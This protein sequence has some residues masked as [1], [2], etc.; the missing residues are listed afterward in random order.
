MSAVKSQASYIDNLREI[1]H[2]QRNEAGSARPEDDIWSALIVAIYAY[3]DDLFAECGVAALP[4]G[5]VN[6][7]HQRDGDGHTEFIQ[8]LNKFTLPFD[9][10]KTCASSWNVAD[11][12]HHQHDRDVFECFGDPHHTVV[13]KYRMIRTLATGETVS[14]VQR[15]VARRFI[16]LDRVV[17]I[18]K[19]YTEGEGIYRRM[20]LDE[21]GWTRLRP[22]TSGPGTLAEVCVRQVPVL[23][24]SCESVAGKVHQLLQDRVDEDEREVTQALQHLLLDDVVAGFDV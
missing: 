22:S 12:Q 23:F 4:L 8:H 15:F 7:I 3:L 17:C 20:Y 19:T 6:S 24:N 18:W 11:R 2:Y 10:E 13:V 21:T 16:R 14:I 9:F 5:V 1:F